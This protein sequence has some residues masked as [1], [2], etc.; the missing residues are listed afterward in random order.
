MNETKVEFTKDELIDI[1]YKRIVAKDNLIKYLEKRVDFINKMENPTEVAIG[2]RDEL[3]D[4][5]ERVRSD[6]YDD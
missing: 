5:L 4:L 2:R 3:K 6:N 1:L